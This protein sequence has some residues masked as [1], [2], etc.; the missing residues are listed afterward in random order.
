M[1]PSGDV[2]RKLLEMDNDDVWLTDS[3]ASIH[4]SFQRDWLAEFEEINN[5]VMVRLGDNK[6]CSVKGEGT[7]HI[8]KLVN[9]EWKDAHIENVLYVP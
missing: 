7:V 6:G 4:M 1:A 5:T 3:G 9:G 2:I 8:K